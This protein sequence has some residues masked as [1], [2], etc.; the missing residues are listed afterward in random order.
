[1]LPGELERGVCVIGTGFIGPVH[2]EALR[3]AGLFVRGVL[4]SSAARSNAAAAQ[5]RVPMAYQSLEE[6]LADPLVFAVHVTTP[7]RHHFSAVEQLLA[8]GKHVMCEK[9]LAMNSTETAKLVELATKA[10]VAAGVAYN[11]RYYPLCVEAKTRIANGELGLIAHLHGSYVQDWLLKPTDFNWRV[12]AEEGGP[13]RAVADIGTHWLDLVQYITGQKVEA[14]QGMLKTIH[15]VRRRPAGPVETFSGKIATK[16]SEAN[17][18][19]IDVA[20]DTED[21]GSVMLKFSGGAIG[22]LWV[23]QATAGRKNCIRFEIG[24]T[25]GAVAWNSETPNELWLGARDKANEVLLK[26]P[27]LLSSRASSL[28]S[29]P[30]GHNEGYPDTFKQLFADFYGAIR[31]GTYKTAPAFPTFADGHWE[32]KIC[33]AILK[34]HQRQG[35]ETISS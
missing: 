16:T 24:G 14:V 28:C 5:L 35:W 29:Y 27:A 11:V 20:V 19:L 15:P 32:L 9:P 30:G 1:M 8:A 33:D 25:G 34:S 23:S 26:D 7:N 17:S 13:L 4:G 21:C 6:V 22:S 3:R 18:A 10:D 31:N 2:V 12:T